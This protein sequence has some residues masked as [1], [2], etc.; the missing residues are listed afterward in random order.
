MHVKKRTYPDK[1]LYSHVGYTKIILVV[2]EMFKLRNKDCSLS[3]CVSHASICGVVRMYARQEENLP[4]RQHYSLCVC[5]VYVWMFELRNKDY[6][7]CM[8]ECMHVKGRTYRATVKAGRTRDTHHSV[9][10]GRTGSA[11]QTPGTLGTAEA[12]RM[13][14]CM[15]EYLYVYA[16]ARVILYAYTSLKVYMCVCMCVYWMGMCTS[17]CGLRA[18]IYM[19]TYIYIYMRACTNKCTCAWSHHHASHVHISRLQK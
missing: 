7:L 3:V 15:Y 9:C 8:C 5:V 12:L 14:V 11:R 13:C 6:S 18:Y 16:R 19:Y 1:H 17:M 2:Y 4:R 10:T